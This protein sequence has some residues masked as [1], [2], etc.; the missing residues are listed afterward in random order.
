MKIN[1]TN[2]FGLDAVELEAGGYEAILIP[3][4]GA[5]LVKLVHIEKGVNILKTPSSDE[6]EVFKS[7]PQIF[8]L[9]L[10]FPPNR[11][12]DGTYTYNGIKYQ[13]PITIPNQNNYHH[14]I[15][16]SQSFTVTKTQIGEDFVVVEA[17]YFSNA[18]NDAIYVNFPHEFECRMCFKLSAAG[19][20]QKVTFINQSDK[21]MPLGVGFHT[22]VM[23]PFTNDGDAANYKL[24]LSVGERWEVSDRSLPTGTLLPLTDQEQLLRTTGLTPT[25]TP[26]EWPL[27]VKPLVI[28]GKEYNGAIITDT[29]SGLSV[30][31]EVD[32]Q[33]KHWTLWN[34]GG[35][36]NWT[37]PE[38]QTW[39]TNAPNL[40]MP[41]DITGFQT[42]APGELWSAVSKLYVG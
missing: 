2:W 3:S 8:G 7:R 14:G 34:N 24:L 27:T 37:C 38:P 33:Y 1:K 32:S 35:Q 13:Y 18:V 41:A 22:P 39:A 42:V 4:V 19:L 17:T 26:I 10:L 20:E 12:E 6:I 28:D 11:I 21:D 40:D 16:K 23:V 36:V 29:I 31:Y 25:G 5:N 30:F 15:I 9:P